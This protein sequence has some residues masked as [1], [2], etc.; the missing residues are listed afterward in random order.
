[1][2]KWVAFLQEYTFVLRH[3]SGNYNQVANVL[4]RRVSL[5]NS[6]SVEMDVFHSIPNM[7]SNDEDFGHIWKICKS[8]QQGDYILQ[9]GFLL[10]A[11]TRVFQNA[12]SENTSSKTYIQD[13]L[14]DIL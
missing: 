11:T 14:V 7:Y 13:D 6:V 10:R 8:G 4:S 9:N 2:Q 12:L 1:M 3:K 5:L